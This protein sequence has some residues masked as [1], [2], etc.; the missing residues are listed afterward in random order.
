MTF[1]KELMKMMILRERWL[2][3]ESGYKFRDQYLSLS[4]KLSL[5]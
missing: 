3:V 4:Q 5:I 2:Y 1:L